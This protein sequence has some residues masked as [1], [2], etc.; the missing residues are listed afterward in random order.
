M[1]KEAQCLLLKRTFSI[2]NEGSC[3]RLEV[4]ENAINQTEKAL[5]NTCLQAHINSCPNLIYNKYCYDTITPCNPS[6][7]KYVTKYIELINV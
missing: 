7:C 5:Y 4:A 6:E 3:I 2:D 1:N